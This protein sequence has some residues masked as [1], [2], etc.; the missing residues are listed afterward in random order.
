M[1]QVARP[2]NTDPQSL[3]EA[4]E[5]DVA[6]EEKT[7]LRE[8]EAEAARIVARARRRNRRRFSLA[9]A[10][11]RSE[12]AASLA[13]ARAKASRARHEV[14]LAENARFAETGLAAIEACLAELWEDA[15]IREAWCRNAVLLAC[16]HLGDVE[17]FVVEHP[18]PL[19]DDTRRAILE[20]LGEAGCKTP[21]LRS[22]PGLRVGIRLRSEHACLDATLRGLMQD[23]TRIA[24]EYLAMLGRAE[25]HCD[26]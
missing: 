11:L 4:I 2:R 9:A 13:K 18:D 8:A 19:S 1:K 22:D 17:R 16:G 20:A 15:A 21:E 25:A 26:G 5:A 23:R 24:G 3:I 6:K 10:K 12:R 7:L 14:I